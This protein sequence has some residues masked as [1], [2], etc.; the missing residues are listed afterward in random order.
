MFRAACSLFPSAE[1]RRWRR[2]HLSAPWRYSC[3]PAYLAAQVAAWPEVV[4]GE[5]LSHGRWCW[6]R[7][8]AREAGAWP[9]PGLVATGIFPCW[10]AWRGV[11]STTHPFT[12]QPGC[13]KKQPN[14]FL[15][16]FGRAPKPHHAPATSSSREGDTSLVPVSEGSRT[17][18]VLISTWQLPV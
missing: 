17:R 5:P 15:S 11:R 8:G 18:A 12:R 16:A 2:W 6:G 7:K 4:S 3:C 13:W 1:K 10:V 14:A 9:F